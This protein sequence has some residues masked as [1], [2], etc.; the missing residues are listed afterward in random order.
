LL[1]EVPLKCH[2]LN[3]QSRRLWSKTIKNLCRA[4]VGN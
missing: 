2:Q 3:S 1:M 4:P